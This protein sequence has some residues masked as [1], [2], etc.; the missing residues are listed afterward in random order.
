A[1]APGH[2]ARTPADLVNAHIAVVLGD[3]AGAID[4]RRSF[5]DLGFTSLMSTDLLTRLK[6]ATGL[7][8]PATLLFDHP[9]PARL[10]E[11]LARDLAGPGAP[12][13]EAREAAP[14][15]EAS[16]PAPGAEPVAIVGMGC[17]FPGG[18][19]RP[20]DLWRL[21]AEGADAITGFPDDR[22]WDLDALRGAGPGAPGTSATGHG[23]FLDD[24]AGF[25]PAFFGISP[26]EANAMD[27]QQRLLLETSW[28]AVERAGIRPGD[29]HGRS[30][31]V[32]V[33]A[34]AQE[35]GP[36]LWEPAEGTGGHLLTGTTG[37]VASGRIAYVLGLEGPALTVDTA[38]SSSLVA[39]HQAVQSLRR[40]ECEMALAGGA[41]VMSSPGMFIQFSAQGG[42]SPDGRCRAFGAGADGTGWAEGAGMLLIEPLSRARE[43]GHPVLAVI[44]GSAINQDG[45][46][47]GLTAPNGAAQERVIARALDDAGLGPADVDAVEAHGTGTPL[48]D[49]IEANALITAYGRDRPAGR[50]LLLGSLKSNIGHAQAAAG[51]GGI[52][53][54]VLALRNEELPRT[55]HADTP[56]P[57]V[58]WDTGALRL[59]TRPV[60]WPQG[61]VPRRAGVSSFGISGTN[62]H[63]IVEEAPPQ[64][65][66]DAR[67]GDGPGSGGTV[68]WVLSART[69][70][71]LRAQAGRLAGFA[72]EH[73]GL[74]PAD[75]GFS[76]ATTRTAF[77]HRAVVLGTRRQDLVDGLAAL[78]NGDPA[79][80]VVTGRAGAS[81]GPVLVFPGQG[82]Q[83]AGMAVELLDTSAVFAARMAECADALAPHTDWP[84][85]ET[86][87]GGKGAARLERV[88]VIQP[89]LWAVMVSLAEV[90]RSLGVVPAAVVG[91]SQGE[92]AAACVAGALSL[93][94]AAKVAALRS[95]A[96]TAL[97]GTG[98]MASVPLGADKVRRRLNG[99]AER[100]HIAAVNGPSTTVVAGERAALEAFTAACRANGV[101]ART[102]DVDY[103]S[104]TP[105]VEVLHEQLMDLLDGIT[106]GSADVAFHST[107]TGG[108]L[109]T[110][111][112]NADYWYCNLRSPVCFQQAVASLIADGHRLF[113]EASPHPVVGIG[114]QECLDEAGV[115]G[116]AIGTL[117]RG[118]GGWDRILTS[119]AQA[120]VNG[121]DVDWDAV[122]ADRPRGRRRPLD[123]P[124]YPFQ[125]RRHWLAPGSAAAPDAASGAG[126]GPAGHP[127][128]AAVLDMAGS[129]ETVFTGRLSLDAHPW[130]AD[131]TVDGTAVLPGTALVDLALHAGRHLDCERL[132][133][134]TLESPLL[135]DAAGATDLQ[136][137]VAP[138]DGTGRRALTVYGRPCGTRDAGGAPWTRTGSG[139][140][141]PADAAVP[142]HDT[143]WPP[144]GA[145]QVDLSGAY[146]RLSDQG[147]G[148]GPAF[149][150]LRAA[151]LSGDGILAE[152]ALPPVA[153]GGGFGIHPALLDAALHP[154]LAPVTGRGP[155][156]GGPQLPFS[157]TGVR[158]H[159]TGA[160]ALRVHITPAGPGAAAL[161]IT[162]PDG[163]PVADIASLTLR[164][165]PAGTIASGTG[166]GGGSLFRMAW[167]PAAPGAVHDVTAGGAAVIGGPGPGLPGARR[168]LDLD[169]LAAALEA[170][171]PAPGTVVAHA[172]LPGGT[173]AEAAGATARWALGL[174]QGWLADDRLAASRL[175]VTTTRAVAVHDGDRPAGL[176]AAP[177]WGLLRSAQ[178]EHPGRFALLDVDEDASAADVAAAAATGAPQAALRCGSVHTPSLAGTDADGT[179]LPA[180]PQW[181]LDAGSGGSIDALAPVAAPTRM[182]LGRGEV[183]VAV[184]AAGL[185]FRDVLITLGLYP[186]RAVIGTEAAGVVEDTGPGVTGM[187]PGDRVMGLFHG[188]AFGV[189]ATT[190]RRLLAPIPDGW[191]FTRAAAVPIAFL[192][193]HHGLVDLAG[194][195]PGQ[196][197]LVHAAAGGVGTAAVQLARS[198]G[199]EVF[200]TASPG[201]WDALRAAG[202]DDAHISDSRTLDFEQR[203]REATRGAGMDAVLNTLAGEFTDASLRLL[204]PGG[205]FVELGKTDVRDPAPEGVA[206]RP[207]DLLEVDP[208]R[209]AEML[210]GLV[211]L[212]DRGD[213]AAPPTTALPVYRAPEAF[214]RLQQAAHVGKIVLTLPPRPAPEGT[215]LITGGTGTLGR[216]VAR[217][218]AARHGAGHLLLVGRRGASAEG[219]DG[220]AAELAGLGCEV[221][222][223]ACDAADRAALAEVIGSIPA[224]HPLTSV[225]H[226]AGVLE[227]G[228]VEALTAGHIDRVFGSKVDAAW[229]LHELTR[230]LPLSSFVLFSSVAGVVGTAGQ[231]NYAAANAFLDA[232]AH[233]RRAEGL[234]ATSLSWGLWEQA[235][236]MTGHLDRADLARM[237]RTG[238]APVATERALELLDAALTTGHPH[239]VP[240]RLDPSVLRDRSA[241]GALPSVVRGLV[242]APEPDRPRQQRVTQGSASS[243]ADRLAGLPEAERAVG[244]EALLRAQV[245]T[246][247]G[248][249][250]PDAV[251]PGGTFEE[252]GFDSLTSVELRN[253]LRSATGLRLPATVAFD[254][255]TVADLAGR[256]LSDLRAG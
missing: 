169:A 191:S 82:A 142:P 195:G 194:T 45:A 124:T 74:D 54:T 58:G 88:D 187:A 238:F 71:A 59:L 91:H 256:L 248:H 231:A 105:H 173:T 222:F 68:P 28:E 234:P 183:R 93:E 160:T 39:L 206:Y 16:A 221:T 136:L 146:A 67:S 230:D 192:T 150:G 113:I 3:D 11:L 73:P 104:H 96:I 25:D 218:L 108:R 33:G 247:L 135:L 207:F 126:A 122:F 215:T 106:P 253:R 236:G 208:D 178:N 114:V 137:T 163:A 66:G 2:R 235:S 176:P 117:R 140:L 237:A 125:H 97:A 47:N 86:V 240:V 184:R 139:T 147:H 214:R 69:A 101:R 172:P 102:V 87:R 177:V 26:R 61:A 233:E 49:P 180:D 6:Q 110:A 209:I 232:L 201:K 31:G 145:Q 149:Q 55:L 242:P 37:S 48:G 18:V 77:E 22:G 154:L 186:G 52:I 130:L 21:V 17:R 212:L 171:L 99:W 161:R 85:L 10:T 158:L 213:L 50:P 241:H 144:P 246:V 80:N 89:V 216:E 43:A 109:D 164:R 23:G 44:R 227:D 226:A 190:D 219:A 179:L 153:G 156:A 51:V 157:W 229:N 211:A 38:C 76:L 189:S 143:A 123:L 165:P 90:W 152:I 8:L 252:M 159:A 182:P 254:Y 167:A 115:H 131:H 239:L 70:P 56:S 81:A 9:T 118:E 119:V 79:P 112:L 19:R 170:G 217:H 36:H 188:G 155:A 53:K 13:R 32:F 64:D 65:A 103:A 57:H 84:L 224:R 7:R 41:A 27:P 116:A 203:F 107:L 148:Y 29:L 30:V 185:N 40:G 4:P 92:I 35:Y 132:D 12:E 245:A 78:R 111:G 198:L 205:T 1:T 166:D 98:A 200:A 133:D 129:G 127:M 5:K 95:R 34:M 60:P 128:L 174:V 62:A 46:S 141:A 204:A 243:W 251:E 14:V 120:H 134:L 75:V 15:Q 199:A 249:D 197:V 223:A 250:S 162:G 42:L 20:E 181:R 225:I 255:P 138:A 168:Y 72:A 193:A 83:W 175:I 210:A 121:A 228:T 151:W 196:R 220:L 63:V 244:L 94:D 100:L 24:A 202:L